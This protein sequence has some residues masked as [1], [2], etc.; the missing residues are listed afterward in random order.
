MAR[1]FSFLLCFHVVERDPSFNFEFFPAFFQ[2]PYNFDCFRFPLFFPFFFCPAWSQARHYLS[3]FFALVFQ[4]NFVG[5]CCTNLLL[6]AFNVGPLV[7]FKTAGRVL[8]GWILWAAGRCFTGARRDRS[9]T[10]RFCR[11]TVQSHAAPREEIGPTPSSRLRKTAKFNFR[12]SLVIFGNL[13]SL[14]PPAGGPLGVK[15][16]RFLARSCRGGQVA[17]AKF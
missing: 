10:S 13:W 2:L 3:H 5:Q 8:A 6:Y 14:S 17:G 12:S 7:W 11:A 1:T 4:N 16:Q 15:N 9:L